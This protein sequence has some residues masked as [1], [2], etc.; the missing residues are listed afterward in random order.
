MHFSTKVGKP[1]ESALLESRTL[2]PKRKLQCLQFFYKMTGSPKDKL[3]I[4]VKMDDGTGTIRKMKKIHTFYGRLF[5][6]VPCLW[7][8]HNA[9]NRLSTC[10]ASKQIFIWL[11]IPLSKIIFKW[12]VPRHHKTHKNINYTFWL[13][14]SFPHC[15][16]DK[17]S[18][19]YLQSIGLHNTRTIT[20][21]FSTFSVQ[22]RVVRH[23]T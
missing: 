14:T 5:F 16:I 18:I 21:Y 22:Q 8:T 2:Y 20:T 6:S 3:V 13:T 4:W 10:F 7:R 11:F 23:N 1:L 19:V 15:L 17:Y 9:S 12:N